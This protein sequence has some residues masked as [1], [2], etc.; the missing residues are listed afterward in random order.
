MYI[1][2]YAYVYN[3]CMYIY[4]YVCICICMI[5]THQ[6]SLFCWREQLSVPSFEKE[7]LEKNDC[8]GDL[9]SFCHAEYYPGGLSMFLVKKRLSKIKYDLEFSI[10]NVGLC[11]LQPNNQLMFSFVEFWFCSI[12]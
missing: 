7:V 11:L 1:C 2:M 9:K 4:V 6:S 3:I 5:Y 12:T 10:T 8:L